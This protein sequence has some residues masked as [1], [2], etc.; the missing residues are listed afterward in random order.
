MSDGILGQLDTGFCT[1]TDTAA[2]GRLSGVLA[3]VKFFEKYCARLH[4]SMFFS[5]RRKN[6]KISGDGLSL[7]THRR[8]DFAQKF[9]KLSGPSPRR[10]DCKGQ[11]LLHQPDHPTDPLAPCCHPLSPH[12][13]ASSHAR[14]DCGVINSSSVSSISCCFSVI[15]VVTACL[16]QSNASESIVVHNATRKSFSSPIITALRRQIYQR[17]I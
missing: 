16:C 11:P 7:R 8:S 10:P 13:F 4:Q 17:V 5:G 3:R 9:Q 15:N 14:F 1:C 6:L 12:I 2:C